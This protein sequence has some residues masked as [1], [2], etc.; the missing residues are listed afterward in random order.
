MKVGTEWIIDAFDCQ[1]EKLAEVSIL[2]SIFDELIAELDLKPAE[3]PFWKK[4]SPPG[5]GVSG[6]VLLTES[7]LA[8]HTYPEHGIA[9]F[10]LYCC[11]ARPDWDWESKL[12]QKLA[13][14]SVSIKVI[15]R[16]S[17]K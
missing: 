3:P 7:H 1:A 11:N 10:N 15:E 16:G 6:L 4:F 2:S 12:K 13:A 17:Q 8:C 9:T 5:S 14:K